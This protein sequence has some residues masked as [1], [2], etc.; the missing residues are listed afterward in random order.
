METGRSRPRELHWY[1]A[2]PMLFGDWGTSRLYVLGLAF[3]FNGRASFWFVA[4]MCVL[5]V[6]VGW[7]YTV[8]C[9]LFPDGGGVYSS[10]RH[11]S[12]LLA[13]IGGLLLCA[14]YVV[15]ASLS[16]LDAF[17]YI[18]VQH[19]VLP[20]GFG[21]DAVLAAVTILLIGGLNVFGPAKTGTIAMVVAL[22]TIALTLVIGLFCLPHLGQA[23]L[24]APTGSAWENWKGFT[25]IVLALSGVE[26]IANM[27]GIM[28]RPVE[29]TA[30]RSIL[31]VM[32][33]IVV[34]NLI[35]AAAMDTLSDSILYTTGGR[36]AHT[37]DMLKVIAAQYVGP[38]FAAASSLVFAALL[39]SA[40]NTA[41]GDLVSI[42]YMLSRDKELPR[43]FSGLNRFGMPM[44]PLVIAA[45]VPAVVLLLFPSV[46][47][48]ADLYAV[49]VVGAIAI[50][51]GS[52][53]T[54]HDLPIRSRERALD[55]GPDGDPDGHRGDHLRRQAARPGL[56]PAGAGAG[57]VGAAG[58]D[59]AEPGRDD[60]PGGSRTAYLAFAGV[61][62]GAG[63]GPV[64]L[65]RA[66]PGSARAW[67]LAAALG[68]G[69]ASYRAQRYREALIAAERAAAPEPPRSMF[70]GLYTPR[71]HVMVA[72]QGNPRLIEFALKEAKNRQAELQ[73]L[74]VRHVAVTPMGPAPATTLAEDAQAQALFEQGPGAG[75][76]GRRAAAIAL[77]R[78]ARHA[79]RDPRPGRHPRRRPAASGRHPPRR[80]LA[81]DEGGRHP[82]RRRAP[83]RAHRPPDPRLSRS[84]PGVPPRGTQ[85]AQ[86]TFAARA[87]SSSL[88]ATSRVSESFSG[89]SGLGTAIISSLSMSW[90]AIT[91]MRYLRGSSSSRR[92]LP[93][94]RLGH[95]HL[96]DAEARA[97]AD[98]V[99]D[100]PAGDAGAQ[101]Q[102]ALAL[103]EDRLGDADLVHDA[104]VVAGD[105]LDVDLPHPQVAQGHR[106]QDAGGDVVAGADDAGVGPLDA[107]ALEHLDLPAVADGRAADHEARSGR[108]PSSLD[109]QRDHLVPL[110]VQR[111]GHAGAE[112]AQADDDEALHE[113]PRIG[114]NPSGRAPG[115]SRPPHPRTRTGTRRPGSAAAG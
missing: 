43:S 57:P 78:R 110:G 65:H 2:G 104:G 74:F 100:A 32:I 4:A 64:L 87:R 28:V 109:V 19:Y 52:T 5:M 101:P 55:A 48:L 6:G 25:E 79:R 36:P 11:R 95:G 103:G 108:P 94:Q 71:E 53:S 77:R 46:E 60:R 9:R 105:H 39:L 13:V 20:G 21:L 68:V 51:L 90:T 97:H 34:L 96:L 27:T 92:D 82:G 10:A 113:P 54:S 66:T 70:P 47:A 61:S 26:A 38:T 29:K 111:L 24:A 112:V 15:T 35:L 8:V 89:A 83:A 84:R 86:P 98:V 50:N 91:E 67:P 41:L 45:V 1:H 12:Q 42:Q 107:D 63:A 88:P 58:D 16:C 37:G 3:A 23:E 75:G 18:G 22:A 40:V 30:R 62:V 76:R 7:S 33:E 73:L 115:L 106:G 114:A 17:H 14:D 80:P 44:L 59:R 69:L 102:G 31:P 81:G 85:S 72:T 93:I 49:G 99:E 56:R